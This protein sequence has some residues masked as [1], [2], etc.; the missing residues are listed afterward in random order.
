[1]LLTRTHRNGRENP[2]ALMDDMRREF[3]RLFLDS[4]FALRTPSART[5]KTSLTKTD[6]GYVLR[7]EVP[8]LTADGLKV[9]VED[10]LLRLAAERTEEAPEGFEARR[11]ERVRYRFDRRLSLPEDVEADK[12]EA[13]VKDGLLTITLPKAE[14][15]A[16][17]QITVQG[18]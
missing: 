5:P 17:R 9:S 2:F 11:T 6:S 1:M 12:I 13:T 3:D 4:P 15:P 16:P 8:G 14:K 18:S 10:G 7:M